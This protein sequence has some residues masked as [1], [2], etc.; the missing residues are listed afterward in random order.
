MTESRVNK[1]ITL[2][3]RLRENLMGSGMAPPPMEDVD[4]LADIANRIELRETY[5]GWLERQVEWL[6]EQLEWCQDRFRSPFDY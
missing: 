5:V 2:L 4:G 6:K 3:L 1:D